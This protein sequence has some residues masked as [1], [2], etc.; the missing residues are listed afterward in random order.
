[1][2]FQ[3]TLTFDEVAEKLLYDAVTGVFTWRV[4]VGKNV[5]AG[6]QAGSIKATRVNAAGNSVSYR[7]IRLFGRTMP[8]GRLAWLLHYGEWP[9]GRVTPKNDDP[10][11][12]RI[13]NL[14]ETHAIV[15]PKITDPAA[16]A[17]YLRK[18][19]EAHPNFWRE[20]HLQKTFGLD[21][22]TYLNMV[23]AQRNLCAICHEPE[24]VVRGGAVKALAVD[25]N[26]LT[27]AVRQLLCQTCNQMVGFSKE[28]PARLRA[29]ADYIEKHATLADNVVPL[30]KDTAQ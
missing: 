18:H 29:A 17:E 21:L 5:K 13:D 22:Q 12:L 6:S 26:H 7:Y 27:G 9:Q 24:T 10:L 23:G 30:N 3:E 1:M 8:A 25:H 19:R 20:Q 4:D 2:P 28:D 11:D 14:T 15:A 16:R